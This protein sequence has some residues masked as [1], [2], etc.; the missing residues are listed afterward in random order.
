[1]GYTHYEPKRVVVKGYKRNDCTVNGI[2]MALGLSYDL[3]KKVLQT[4]E[5]GQED[6]SFRKSAP[7]PKT[8]FA[9]RRNILKLCGALSVEETHYCE[10]EYGYN[11]VYHGEKITAS[12]F[13]E[14]NPRGL[15]IIL[16]R[17]HLTTIV[18]GNVVDAWDSSQKIVE[19][20]FKIDLN[21]S[22]ELIKDL[23]SFYKM[24]NDDH[25]IKN[26]LYNSLSV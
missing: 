16:V 4:L 17:G 8:Q 13:A 15:Y 21:T 12:Q 19:S 10:Y 5:V 18:N 2:G 7:R 9:E 1:M 14:E 11:A 22:R 6:I 26:N 25:I 24:N 23:A 20:A 3:A